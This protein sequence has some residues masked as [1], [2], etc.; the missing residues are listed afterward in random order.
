MSWHSK[1]LLCSTVARDGKEGLRVT[2]TLWATRRPVVCSKAGC[3]SLSSATM[4]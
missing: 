4:R 3:T 1:I 2:E